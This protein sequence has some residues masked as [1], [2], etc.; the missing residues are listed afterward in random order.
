MKAHIESLEE[1]DGEIVGAMNDIKECYGLAR[2]AHLIQ[3]MNR[4]LEFVEPLVEFA[5]KVLRYFPRLGDRRGPGPA[6][7]AGEDPELGHAHAS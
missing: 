3:G 4:L 1:L 6:A 2:D 7:P 5:Q